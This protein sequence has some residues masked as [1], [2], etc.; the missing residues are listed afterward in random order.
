MLVPENIKRAQLQNTRMLFTKKNVN[1][2]GYGYKMTAG[3]QVLQP[4][5]IVFVTRKQPLAELLKKDIIPS[6]IDD[7]VVDVRE[8]GKIVAYKA[9]TDRWRPAPPGVSIGH[10]LITAGTFGAV[11][12]D[13]TTGQKLILSNNH[14]MA[15]SNDAAK[16]DAILQPG[17]AD[18]GLN[19]QDLIARL[20]RFVRIEMNGGSD[21][22]DS[23]G[24]CSIAKGVASVLNFAAKMIG[25]S[26]RLTPVKISQTANLVDC[27][28]AKP[29]D[30]SAIDENIIDIGKITG[31]KTAELGM[32]VRKSGRTT[33]TTTGTIEALDVTTEVSYGGNKV[34][35][36][37]HQFYSSNMSQPGDSGSLLVDANEPKA[38]GLLFAGSDTVTVYSPIATVLQLLNVTF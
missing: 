13:I 14:V 4:S 7:I 37:E 10:Y 34:A 16:G 38:V 19:P 26:H 24:I 3:K 6:Q 31:V 33:A 18:G 15:N 1:G 20:E 32:N 2:I 17:K 25:S 27:A 11:V 5:L 35:R 21:G 22:G 12:K 9:R 29:I 23:G 28:V 8:I 36:F 30:S